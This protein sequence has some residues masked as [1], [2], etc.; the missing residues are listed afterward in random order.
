MILPSSTRKPPPNLK[1]GQNRPGI[2]L[3]N[4]NPAPLY[5]EAHQK[6]C[7]SFFCQCALVFVFVT[8]PLHLKPIETSG[9]ISEQLQT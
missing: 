7:A 4:Q 2:G 3:K 9:M 6:W 5:W 8:L 1:K